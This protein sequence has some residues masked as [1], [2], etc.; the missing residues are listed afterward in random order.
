MTSFDIQLDATLGANRDHVFRITIADREDPRGIPTRGLV[1]D[2]KSP[3]YK[4][5]KDGVIEYAAI[6]PPNS[7][8]SAHAR[9]Q[10]SGPGAVRPHL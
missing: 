4:T 3:G 6:L 8:R 1:G 5:F 2:A 10:G 7:K 9:R